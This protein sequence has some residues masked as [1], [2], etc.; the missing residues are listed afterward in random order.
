MKF[1]K[2]I[3]LAVIMLLASETDA[4]QITKDKKS[5]EKVKTLVKAMKSQDEGDEDDKPKD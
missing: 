3:S 2:V 5:L 4:L 1:N